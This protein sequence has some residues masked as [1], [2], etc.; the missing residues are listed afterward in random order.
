MGDRSWWNDEYKY[1]MLINEF[2]YVMECS[3][4]NDRCGCS[5][6]VNDWELCINEWF[7]MT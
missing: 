6:S 1:I 5:L 3:D 2:E 4:I 7:D